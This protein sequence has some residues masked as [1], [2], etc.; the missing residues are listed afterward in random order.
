MAASSRKAEL[1]V[2]IGLLARALEQGVPL[3]SLLSRNADLHRRP[4]SE[5]E[6]TPSKAAE[7]AIS[8]SRSQFMEDL[9]LLPTPT[10]LGV[11]RA[12]GEQPR[13]VELGALDGNVLSNTIMLENCSEW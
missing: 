5:K 2:L 12:S 4:L 1:H 8:V 11:A 10:L 3:G 6:W 9:A 7:C 13:F